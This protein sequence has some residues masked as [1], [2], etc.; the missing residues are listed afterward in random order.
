MLQPGLATV[1]KLGTV[2]ERKD[3]TLREA[4]QLWFEEQEGSTPNS[5]EEEPWFQGDGLNPTAFFF[6]LLAI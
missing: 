5:G 6:Y 3:R 1:Q 4:L 2:S